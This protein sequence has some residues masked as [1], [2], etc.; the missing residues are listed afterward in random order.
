MIWR[1]KKRKVWT[2]RATVESPKKNTADID[3]YIDK[4]RTETITPNLKDRMMDAWAEC[5]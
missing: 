5:P 1:P 3:I 4:K 2:V